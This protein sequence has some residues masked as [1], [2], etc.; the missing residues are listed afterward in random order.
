MALALDTDPVE[1]TATPTMAEFM[2]SEAYVRVLAGPVGGGKSVCCAHELMRMAQEQAPNRDNKRLS[3]FLIVRNTADQLRSTTLKTIKDWF[4]A[5][6]AYGNWVATERTLYYRFGMPD[7]TIVET[8]WMLRALDDEADIRNALSLEVSAMWG[9]ECRE[10]HPEV[11]RALLKRTNRYPSLK[12][13]GVHATRAGGIFDTN[14]PTMDT[15]WE[16]RMSHPPERWSVHIQP[17]AVLTSDEFIATYEE[18]PD[19]AWT[20]ASQH[21]EVYTVNPLADNIGNLAPDYYPSAVAED[22]KD[23]INTYLRCKF[24]RSLYGLPVYD[25]TFRDDVHL[26]KIPLTHINS[27]TYPLFIGIDFGRT[28]A[29]IFVQNR[30]DGR[31]FVLDEICE[32]NMGM[33]AFVAKR[34]KPLLS[35]RFA[36]VHAVI[37]ADPAGWIKGQGEDRCPVDYLKEAGFEVVKPRTNKPNLRI[38]AVETLLNASVDGVTRLCVDPRCKTLVKGFRGGYKWATNKLGELSNEKEPVKNHP[39][40]DIHD[41][42]QYV[43]LVCD[44]SFVGAR[45]GTGRRAI[46]VAKSAG[47]V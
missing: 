12:L 39:F 26:S 43:A 30:P 1:F 47:W 14:M 28:P 16:Q 35:E 34:I 20:A 13:G 18:D 8:E 7:G 29:A 9:N 15:W 22:K 3:R 37:A 33:G 44:G 23:D 32:T 31:T 2:R 45:T 24:G 17:P 4:P 21:G 11:V 46:S 41:A 27:A 40:S 19:P 10:L 6:S 5:P 42:L 38:L 36:G 25:D